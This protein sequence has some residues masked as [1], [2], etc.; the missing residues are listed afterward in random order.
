[1]GIEICHTMRHTV[2]RARSIKKSAG[3]CFVCGS[4]SFSRLRRASLG[5]SLIILMIQYA[6]VAFRIT[7]TGSHT[8]I[9]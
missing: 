7:L 2:K 9:V 8:S 5:L 1:M 3:G 6:F 4:V